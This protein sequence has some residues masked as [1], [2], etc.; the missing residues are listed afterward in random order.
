MSAITIITDL[1]NKNGGVINTAE[2]ERVGVSRT[3]ISN[4]CRDGLLIRPAKGQYTLPYEIPD[5]LYM[6]QQRMQLLVFSHETALFLH[7]IAERTP[8]LHSVTLPSNKRLS[9]TFP[10]NLK[11]YMIMPELFEIGLTQLPTKM[12]NTVRSYDLERTVC[13]VLRSRGRI[14]D[15]TVTGAIKNYCLRKDR[16]L[17]K[18]GEYADIFRMTKILRQYLEVLL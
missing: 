10:G 13:D 9:S 1:I 5:E 17:N 4:L 14:D 7:D 12:G 15:Q 11:V 16:N 6:W 2:I 3:T 8:T 18:L